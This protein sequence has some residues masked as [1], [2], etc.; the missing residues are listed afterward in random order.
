MKKI[1][2]KIFKS[3]TIY[4]FLLLSGFIIGLW[5]VASGA[6][7][8]GGNNAILKMIIGMILFFVGLIGIM[9]LGDEE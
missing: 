1:L 2:R 3:P 6:N 9:V 8:N 4:A 7:Y 5:G